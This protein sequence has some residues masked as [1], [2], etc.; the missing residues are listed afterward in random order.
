MRYKDTW[1]FGMLIANNEWDTKYNLVSIWEFEKPI[2]QRY[3]LSFGLI[4]TSYYI[5]LNLY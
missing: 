3:G 4:L 2:L 5:I 1:Q